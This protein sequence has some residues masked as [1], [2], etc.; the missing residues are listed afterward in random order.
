MLYGMT[1]TGRLH[2]T[3][4]WQKE[5]S[6]V[7]ITFPPCPGPPRFY[8]Q[9]IQKKGLSD[10]TSHF[11]VVIVGGCE[12]TAVLAVVD[13]RTKEVLHKKQLRGDIGVGEG[14]VGQ[15]LEGGCEGGACQFSVVSLM[16]DKHHRQYCSLLLSTGQL[17]VVELTSGNIL[18]K[19]FQTNICAGNFNNNISRHLQFDGQLKLALHQPLLLGT[20]RIAIKFRNF[21]AFYDLHLH[22]EISLHH[23]RTL[24]ITSVDGRETRLDDN[25]SQELRKQ[26]GELQ[27]RVRA[28]NNY[29]SGIQKKLDKGLRPGT[30][31]QGVLSM[32][33]KVQLVTSKLDQAHGKARE[34]EAIVIASIAFDN[35]YCHALTLNRDLITFDMLSG[36]QPTGRSASTDRA[37]ITRAK[38]KH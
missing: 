14:G 4:L 36:L 27:K 32:T 7:P 26:F 13:V 33:R 20:Q 21:V 15:D 38:A 11:V 8:N 37:R 31:T 6:P 16:I 5:F 17:C 34:I 24:R 3:P 2:P 12:G 29:T 10:L 9:C 1:R 19:R 22:S 28:L 23:V 30:V 25:P 35:R 18:F